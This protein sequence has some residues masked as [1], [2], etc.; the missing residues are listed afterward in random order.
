MISETEGYR[1]I[2]NI[3]R[4]ELLIAYQSWFDKTLCPITNGCSRRGYCHGSCLCRNTRQ[5]NA[6]QLNRTFCKMP[7]EGQNLKINGGKS[8]DTNIYLF[9]AMHWI[10]SRKDI[11]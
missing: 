11:K 8:K 9:G 4:I 5:L 10:S 1:R 3:G 7:L 6:T 2:R